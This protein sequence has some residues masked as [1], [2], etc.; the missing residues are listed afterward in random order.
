MNKKELIREIIEFGFRHRVFTKPV[1]I[2]EIRRIESG[3]NEPA[4]IEDLIGM[5]I[6]AS[7]KAPKSD[8]VKLKELYL[9][10][11][12]LRFDLELKRIKA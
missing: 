11:N 8:C 7:R 9:R 4:F 1:T 12:D 3:L 5:V 10:L 6:K 2:K